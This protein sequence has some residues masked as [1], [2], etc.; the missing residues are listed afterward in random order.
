M[1]YNTR[2]SMQQVKVDISGALRCCYDAVFTEAPPGTRLPCPY[3]PDD[4]NHG[5][6]MSEE[7]V[8]KTVRDAGNPRKSR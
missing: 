6:V 3:A 5:F 7:G 4:P 1:L 8:W 2:R